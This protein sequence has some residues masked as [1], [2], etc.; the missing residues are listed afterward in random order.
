MEVMP[1]H[2][3]YQV[4]ESLKTANTNDTN[5]VMGNMMMT[6]ELMELEEL[7]ECNNK[8]KLW[9]RARGIDGRLPLLHAAAERYLK[10]SHMSLIFNAYM[11]GIIEIDMLTG[12]PL[13]ML[14]AVG[15]NCD[16]E[17][18]YNL[19]REYPSA[20]SF[21]DISITGSPRK[22]VEKIYQDSN[23]RISNS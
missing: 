19:L 11:P 21:I 8:S 9:A 12:M 15:S 2:S 4:R 14:A 18:V 10:W 6:M 17:S 16:I 3:Y 7:E 22:R 1:K 13:F 23:V 5:W 20:M